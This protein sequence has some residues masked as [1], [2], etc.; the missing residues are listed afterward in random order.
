MARCA[1]TAAARAA[2]G[3]SKREEERVALR[4]VLDSAGVLDGGTH[5]P[6]VNTEKSRV[7]RARTVQERGRAFDV[8]EQQGPHGQRHARNSR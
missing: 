5:D 2:V 1:S 6:T 3:E 8:S 4:A 7:L